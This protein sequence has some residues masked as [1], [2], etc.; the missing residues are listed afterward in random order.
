M[1]S[2]PSGTGGW[3]DLARVLNAQ[4]DQLNIVGFAQKFKQKHGNNGNGNDPDT[5]PYKFGQFV[6]R[7]GGFLTG[8]A[9]GQFLIDSGRRHWEDNSLDLLEYTIKRSLTQTTPIQINFEVNADTTGSP[10]AK[11]KISDQAGTEL[12]TTAEID[13][14]SSPGSYKVTIWCPPNNPRPNP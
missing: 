10:K 7:H 6:D 4:F 8:T 13:G 3:G 2:G 5:T 14:V 11:A 1:A 12:K 9:L